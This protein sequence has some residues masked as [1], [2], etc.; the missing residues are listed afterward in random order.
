MKRISVTGGLVLLAA[1]SLPTGASSQQWPG[2]SS[3]LTSPQTQQLMATLGYAPNDYCGFYYFLSTSSVGYFS[4]D[5][6]RVLLPMC[7]PWPTPEYPGGSGSNS[8][9][10]GSGSTGSGTTGGSTGGTGSTGGGTGGEGGG[11]GGTGG[12]G[13]WTGGTT[14]G[15]GTGGEGGGTG[16]PFGG[17]GAMVTPEPVSLILLGT[18][19]AGIGGVR[20][21]RR[22]KDLEDDD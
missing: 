4:E 3:I 9:P 8:D 2:N 5:L 10:S 20:A 12:E 13:G 17:E 7:A 14:G 21:A 6:L 1:L 22:R 18:G 11:T 16:D 19:L 15:G